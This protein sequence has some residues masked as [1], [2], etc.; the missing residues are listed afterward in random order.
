M[1][2]QRSAVLA[3]C[4]TKNAAFLELPINLCICV[5]CVQNSLSTNQFESI[6]RLIRLVIMFFTKLRVCRF[7]FS[8]WS[9]GRPGKYGAKLK[10]GL[11]QPT[12]FVCLFICLVWVVCTCM[13]VYCVCILHMFLSLFDRFMATKEWAVHKCMKF[14]RIA[15]LTTCMQVL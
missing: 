15:W 9:L 3:A 2:H 11:M 6:L 10:I 8:Q 5:S 14:K 7:F 13:Y 1:K 12:Y 4:G